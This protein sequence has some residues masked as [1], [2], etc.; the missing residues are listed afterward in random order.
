MDLNYLVNKLA[1]LRI[2]HFVQIFYWGFDLFLFLILAP[3]YIFIFITAFINGIAIKRGKQIVIAGLE[4]VIDKTV[5]RGKYFEEKGFKVIYYSFE[6]TGKRSPVVEDNKIQ[7]ANVFLSLDI[8]HFWILC[9]KQK[10][11]YIELY[12]EKLGLRQYFYSLM[13]VA[14]TTIV[15]IHRGI[16][17]DYFKTSVIRNIIRDF[18]Y[19]NSDLILYRDIKMKEIFSHKSK[20]KNKIFYDHNR[21]KV[22]PLNQSVNKSGYNIL[23]LNGIR[24]HRR[25]DLVIESASIIKNHFPD[26][27][28]TIVGCRNE[29]EFSIVNEL[30]KKNKVKEI[31]NVEYW[32]NTPRLYYENASIFIFPSDYV[33]CNYSLLESME[34]GVPA[35]VADVEDAEK[36]IKHGVNGYLSRQTA[37][38]LAKYIVMLL[39]NEDH[40]L[41]M[42]LAA[43]QTII[44]KFD[45]K[46]RMTPIYNLLLNRYKYI[47]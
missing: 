1:N 5:K 11:V 4:H 26:V 2:K 25:I 3:I 15:S 20:F 33:F 13:H 38:D 18:A 27:R 12:F 43:R 7:K 10:P 17:R 8:L 34:R 36:I 39:S 45:D 35:I 44:E 16:A 22:N 31:V 32:T 23:F 24:D 40:R 41:K 14:N 42:G 6:L 28:Y 29:E 30:I 47:N 19:N 46:E 37:V 9:L 21:V